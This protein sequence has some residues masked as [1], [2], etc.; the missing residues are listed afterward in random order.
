MLYDSG[1]FSFILYFTSRIFNFYISINSN[2]LS[3]KKII[4][5]LIL[6]LSSLTLIFPLLYF[7]YSTFLNEPADVLIRSQEILAYDR[8]RLTAI[9]EEWIFRRWTILGLFLILLSIILYFRNIKALLLIGVPFILGA[10]TVVFATITDNL[11][12]TLLFGQRVSVY[13]V[14]LSVSLILCKIIGFCIKINFLNFYKKILFYLSIV[15][16]FLFSVFGL[17]K[18]IQ[19]H[20]LFKNNQ[21]H[22]FLSSLDFSE[23]SLLVPLDR[24]LIRLNAKIPIFIDLKNHP[25]KAN[26]VIEWKERNIL[27]KAFYSQS[28]AN[29]K[30]IFSEIIKKEKIIYILTDFGDNLENCELIFKDEKSKVYKAEGCY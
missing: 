13:L 11:T 7:L 30:S 12:A 28:S 26:K 18:T 19:G 5:P 15:F 10:S 21:L 1:I 27:V 20:M 16:L 24:K 4:H 14:P 17:N 9:L 8:M 25:Y 23:G 29:R 3:Q 2:I 22:A 6:G